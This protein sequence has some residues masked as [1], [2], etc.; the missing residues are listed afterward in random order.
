MTT[1]QY[2]SKDASRCSYGRSMWMPRGLVAFICLSMVNACDVRPFSG[3]DGDDNLRIRSVTIEDLENRTMPLFSGSAFHP[4]LAGIPVTLIFREF[5]GS[6]GTFTL[7]RDAF[8]QADGFIAVANACTFE[9]T[10][11]SFEVGAGPQT[12]TILIDP[13]EIGADQRLILI[14][15]IH[16]AE[17]ATKT[18]TC[19]GGMA[20]GIPEASVQ[21]DFHGFVELTGS[22]TLSSGNTSARGH[23]NVPAPCTFDVI[24]SDFVPTQ[25]PR[26][27]SHFIFDECEVDT[28]SGRLHAESFNTDMTLTCHLLTD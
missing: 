8:A 21:L 7:V 27:G 15:P 14:M 9:I 20:F 6:I 17:L 1:M 22:F 3:I 19:T 26:A 16:P 28:A 4:A 13:C 25:G 24:A 18:F 11:S 12:G 2:F 23:I 10:A 5:N